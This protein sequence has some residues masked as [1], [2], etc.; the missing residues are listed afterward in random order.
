MTG[1]HAAL[2]SAAKRC[3]LAF[4]ALALLGVGPA[5]AQDCLRRIVGAWSWTAQGYP[6]VDL[7]I[8]PDGSGSTPY[9]S[10]TFTCT[11]N[12][13]V[14]STGN[15]LTM[16]GDGRRMTGVSAIGI[17]LTVVRKGAPVAEGAAKTAV[18]PPARAATKP[19]AAESCVLVGESAK[20]YF[21]GGYSTRVT[22]SPQCS[23][24]SI[25]VDFFENGK[26]VGGPA[27]PGTIFSDKPVT[28]SNV[29]IHR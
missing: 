22:L 5:A 1:L 25:N 14:T 4:V 12:Q 9:A 21:G 23:G 27:V 8:Q 13:V 29:R 15:R 6:T 7:V 18:A 19:P 24:A 20:V 26:W 11:G 17:A 10:A 3:L 2:M 16:S 28:N